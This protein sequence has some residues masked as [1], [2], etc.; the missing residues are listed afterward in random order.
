L[1]PILLKIYVNSTKWISIGNCVFI[2]IFNDPLAETGI[3]I[4]VDVHKRSGLTPLNS[5]INRCVHIIQ[6]VKN[7]NKWITSFVIYFFEDVKMYNFIVWTRRYYITV[8]WTVYCCSVHRTVD[9]VVASRQTPTLRGRFV[10][11][12]V[13]TVLVVFGIL[14]RSSRVVLLI[15]S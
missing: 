5:H 8:L 10:V 4:Y 2:Y 7:K 6:N 1:L 9:V 15:Y 14:P 13:V 11:V 3:I 12:V